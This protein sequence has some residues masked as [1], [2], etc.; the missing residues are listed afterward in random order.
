MYIFMLD[1]YAVHDTSCSILCKSY[2]F[3][4]QVVNFAQYSEIDTFIARELELQKIEV[5]TPWEYM[6][7]YIYF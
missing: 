3:H 4:I 2:I 5:A 6:Y 7:I 1:M